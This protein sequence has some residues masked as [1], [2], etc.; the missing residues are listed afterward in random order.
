[1]I[2]SEK[3]HFKICLLK[4]KPCVPYT[5]PSYKPFWLLLNNKWLDVS[6]LAIFFIL[7]SFL[8]IPTNSQV[9]NKLL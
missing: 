7:I 9:S 4:W 3:R 1:L 6:H 8:S 2:E 5:I